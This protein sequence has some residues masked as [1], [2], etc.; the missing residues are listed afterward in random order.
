MRQRVAAQGGARGAGLLLRDGLQ[1]AV[2]EHAGVPP[3]GAP[4]M[5]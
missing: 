1:G 3:S 2:L 5:F 4:V